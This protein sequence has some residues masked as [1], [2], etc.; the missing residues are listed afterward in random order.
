MTREQL[1]DRALKNLGALPAGQTAS[2]EDSEAIDNLIDP[3]IESLNARDI[4]YIA[5]TDEIPDEY[6]LPIAECL[7][8]VAAPEY[9][10][11]LDPAR[12][13]PDGRPKAEDELKI[14]QSAR[15]GYTTL[16]V[17]FF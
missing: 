16:K 17:D 11:T 9:G 7:A 8:W 12:L 14:M 3:L 13:R 6:F 4:V 10:M 5:D 2:P 1:I 15:P